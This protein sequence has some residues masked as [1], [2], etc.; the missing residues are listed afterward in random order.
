MIQTI[1]FDLSEVL[2][3]GLFG[4]EKP[5]AQ[6]LGISE[7]QVIGAFGGARLHD[8]CR[9]EISEDRYLEQIIAE[10]DWKIS[11]DAIKRIIRAN[12]HRPV[13]DMDALVARL[14]TRYELVLLSDHAAEWIAYIRSIHSVL[15][16]FPRQFFSYELT[17]TKREPAM[18]QIVLDAIQRNPSQCLFIDDTEANVATARAL[19]IDGIVFTSVE[20]LRK[21]LIAQGVW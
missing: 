9:G 17:Q 7:H 11:L 10:R 12:F 18:F 19:G 14:A 21:T 3:A 20:Q 1:L 6:Q 8:L 13:R 2:I 15:D 16:Y 5:L 4:I